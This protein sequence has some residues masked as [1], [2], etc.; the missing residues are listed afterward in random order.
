MNRRLWARESPMTDTKRELIE[1]IERA[2]KTSP[3]RRRGMWLWFLLV[4]VVAAA[5]VLA[6]VLL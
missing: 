6:V 4:V 5:G 1:R 3:Q 2:Q